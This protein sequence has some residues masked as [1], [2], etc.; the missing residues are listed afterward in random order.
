MQ[1]VIY[2]LS[3]CFGFV[4][5]CRD[6]RLAFTVL[7]DNTGFYSVDLYLLYPYFILFLLFLYVLLEHYCYMRLPNHYSKSAVA[8]FI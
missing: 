3:L 5:I 8:L 4:V 7:G 1:H 2:V 6:K